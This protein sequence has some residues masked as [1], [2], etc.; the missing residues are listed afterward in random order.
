MEELSAKQKARL[1]RVARLMLGIYQTLVR[2]RY[3][4]AKWVIEGPHDV[5][6]LIPM[7]RK[8]DLDDSIIYLYSRLPYIEAADDEMT[9]DDRVLVYSAGDDCIWDRSMMESPDNLLSGEPEDGDEDEDSLA[10]SDEGNAGDQEGYD[11]AEEYTEDDEEEDDAEADV[12]YGSEE[13]DD[14]YLYNRLNGGSAAKVLRHLAKQFA[15]FERDPSVGQ[16]PNDEWHL[17]LTKPLYIKH[18]WPND[19]FNGKAFDVDRKRALAVYEAKHMAKKPLTRLSQLERQLEQKILEDFSK[20]KTDIENTETSK[21]KHARDTADKLCPGGIALREW[22][23]P[24]WEAEMLRVFLK[25]SVSYQKRMQ[26]EVT[27]LRAS[28]EDVTEQVK[29]AEIKMYNANMCFTNVKA[30]YQESQQEADRLY[31]GQTFTEVT[32]WVPLDVHDITTS[33]E[34]EER[35]LLDMQRLVDR[36]RK[37]L[38]TVPDEAPMAR[39]DVSNE[40]QHLEKNIE[41]W[42][43]LI[44]RTISI[45]QSKELQL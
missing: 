8:Y 16:L 34:L 41:G 30:A 1:D 25:Q 20:L 14:E 33:L 6:H 12:E 27:R 10:D 9:W 36:Y 2:M 24:V 19:N 32:G 45:K 5:Q 44:A 28:H 15:T 38:T 18:G 43:A 21:L 11:N 35:E 42:R 17:E 37:W 39:L 13:S 3:L 40:I 29:T 23:I 22:L 7:Y 31:P 26:E 4:D